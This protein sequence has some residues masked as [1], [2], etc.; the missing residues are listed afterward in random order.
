[1]KN[2]LITQRVGKDKYGEY[3]DYLESSYIK[4]FNQYNINPIILPNNTKDIIAFY[5][6]NKCSRIILTGGDDISESLYNKKS[7]KINSNYYQRDINEKKL[8]KYSIKENIPILGICRGFQIINVCLG[9]NLT[10]NIHKITKVINTNKHKVNF[11]KDFIKVIKK[12]SILV[13]S[14]H[15]QGITEKQLA[16]NLIP[17]GFSGDGQLVE[18]YKHNKLPILGMQWHPERKNFSK[19]FDKYIF[20]LFLK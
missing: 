20:K 1:M 3:Y 17:L 2:I 8:I 4:Y 14:F 11:T 7:K 10:K 5:K 6:N 19:S 15:N 12:K 18:L 9:G 13:N 16:N